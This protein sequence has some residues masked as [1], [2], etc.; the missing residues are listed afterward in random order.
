MARGRGRRAGA[1]CAPRC[2]AG[3]GWRRASTPAARTR[4]AF[5]RALGDW[6]L[7]GM[8]AL[9]VVASLPAVGALLVSTLLVVPSAT[10]RLLAGSMRGLLVGG[11][12]LALAEGIGGLWLADETNLPPGPGDRRARRRRVRRR[13]HRREATMT[14]V[15]VSGPRHGLRARPAGAERRDVLAGRR[16]RRSPCSGPTAAGRR[17][18][19]ELLLGELPVLGGHVRGR[20][21]PGL[22]RP[23][24]PRAAGLPGE[25]ARR[26]PHGRLRAHARVAAA[27][28]AASA[29][30]RRRCSTASASRR[31]RGDAVRRAV[32]RPA[33]AGA[34]RAGAAAGRAAA[35][36]RRAVH[37]RRP[38]ERGGPARHPRRA[39]R[40]GPRAAGV[41]ARHRPRAALGP[42]AVPQRRRR[43][44]SG[45]RRTR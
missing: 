10:A 36:A 37:R 21:Q 35:A 7:L 5:P 13:G 29:S 25:R 20:G 22:R 44:R 30:G 26:R 3:P 38:R 12:A 33:P 8:L 4:S 18:S 27:R 6:L 43:S 1:R 2:S 45:R 32:R 23:V 39:A 31:R 28:A 15:E 40:R 9:A 14:L 42:G 41:D 11:V 16:A 17:R 34:H 24:G 19:C